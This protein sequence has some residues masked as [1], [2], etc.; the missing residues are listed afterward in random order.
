MLSL[1]N[2]HFTGCQPNA[3]CN[4]RFAATCIS[5]LH[6]T[7]LTDHRRYLGVSPAMPREECAYK[8]DRRREVHT[9]YLHD[10]SGGAWRSVA[11]TRC[12]GSPRVDSKTDRQTYKDCRLLGPDTLHS[13][14][15][16]RQS[17]LSDSTRTRT[18]TQRRVSTQK[19]RLLTPRRQ[20]LCNDF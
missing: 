4:V 13:D 14:V 20:Y 2:V 1:Y 5:M 8:R 17:P 16:S 15:S 18:H 6:W 11:L 9:I 19:T 3:Y 7:Y 10:S 12:G